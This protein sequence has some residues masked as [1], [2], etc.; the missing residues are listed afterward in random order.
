M[1]MKINQS[2]QT[3]DVAQQKCILVLGMNK[4]L[5]SLLTMYLKQYISSEFVH[6]S[7]EEYKIQPEKA[8]F[9]NA[10]LVIFE[11]D[12]NETDLV[13][14]MIGIHNKNIL[15]FFKERHAKAIHSWIELGVKGFL[16]EN[17]SI[18]HL[19]EAVKTVQNG[20]Y[21]ISHEDSETIF[22]NLKARTY[23]FNKSLSLMTSINKLSKKE[24]EVI[25]VI[26]SNEGSLLKN[27]S[28]KMFL[29]SHTLRNHLHSIYKKLNI[30]NRVDLYIF[31]QKNEHI[32]TELF[33]SITLSKLQKS[34]HVQHR[35]IAEPNRYTEKFSA[36]F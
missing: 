7:Y 23:N 19:L 18:E 12:Q 35:V 30:R 28:E 1:L 3:I 34:Q 24:L 14:D 22:N 27:V 5:F 4:I 25:Q 11:F 15:A 26:V 10:D 8:C 20:K 16:N 17:R 13:K 2:D 29:S 33:A 21:Y 36:Q 31:H 9:R 6:A 32:F